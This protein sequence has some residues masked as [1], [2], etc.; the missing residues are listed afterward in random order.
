M[1]IHIIVWLFF[2][3]V[4]ILLDTP[5]SFVQSREKLWKPFSQKPILVSD[6]NMEKLKKKEKE[7]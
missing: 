4:V 5:S 2:V 3:V 6:R 1:T 7:E